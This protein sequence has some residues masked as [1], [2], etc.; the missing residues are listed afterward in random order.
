[1]VGSEEIFE[2]NEIKNVWVQIEERDQGTVTI[3]TGADTIFD[4]VDEDNTVVQASAQASVSNNGTAL[5]KLYGLV[6]T[7]AA[8]FVDG[9]TYKVRFTAK[10]GAETYKA[11]RPMRVGEQRL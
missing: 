4:V 7:T 8:E 9:S 11:Y 2:K 6:D 5:V 10:I 3:T 1:M